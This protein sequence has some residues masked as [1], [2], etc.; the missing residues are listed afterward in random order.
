MPLS[1]TESGKVEV[2]PSR[3]PLLH[4]IHRSTLW[5]RHGIGIAEDKVDHIFTVP[6]A[7]RALQRV[8]L[9]GTGLG[10]SIVKQLVE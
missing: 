8:S 3:S 2:E 10:L 4:Q 9:G 5:F 7:S 1:F 6:R